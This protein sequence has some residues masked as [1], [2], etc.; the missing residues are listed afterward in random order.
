[1]SILYSSMVIQAAACAF[2]L[3]IEFII[4]DILIQKALCISS[5][6]NPSSHFFLEHFHAKFVYAHRMSVFLFLKVQSSIW[7]LMINVKFLQNTSR[8]T[9]N[10]SALQAFHNFYVCV[11]P[12]KWLPILLGNIL[13]LES[14]RC[15]PCGQVESTIQE[16]MMK[17]YDLSKKN[18]SKKLFKNID[19]L[20]GSTTS[21]KKVYDE[22]TRSSFSFFPQIFVLQQNN[23]HSSRCI[24]E[25]A[26]T[27]AT[28][29]GR[30]CVGLQLLNIVLFKNGAVQAA[31]TNRCHCH[32]PVTDR[33]EGKNFS[34]TQREWFSLL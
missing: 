22:L 3:H 27:K 24:R 12:L 4:V 14:E 16:Q 23:T 32:V 9:I 21:R 6:A 15:L 33:D 10:K 1:M 17:F 29:V 20:C 7:N 26:C 2:I 34:W 13:I 31:A 19:S 30:Q 18:C 28:S 8:S 25:H 11:F 5:T